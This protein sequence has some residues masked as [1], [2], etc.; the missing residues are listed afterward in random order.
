MSRGAGRRRYCINSNP[1]GRDPVE[2]SDDQCCLEDG[3]L[4]TEARAA[5]IRFIAIEDAA[6][7]ER[8]VL[9]FSFFDG[10]VL[11]GGAGVPGCGEEGHLFYDLDKGRHYVAVPFAYD[12][13][14]A[15]DYSRQGGLL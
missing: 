6:R 11:P 13:P 3:G 5:P 8:A 1:G 9:E 12:K 15:K 4:A 10:I 2:S 14:V 7:F